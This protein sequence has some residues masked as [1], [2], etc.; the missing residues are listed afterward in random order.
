MDLQA[1]IEHLYDLSNE[2]L[3]S[4]ALECLLITDGPDKRKV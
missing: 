1:I 2:E 3:H 4:L